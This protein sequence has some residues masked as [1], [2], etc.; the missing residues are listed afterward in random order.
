MNS[1]YIYLYIHKIVI[2]FIEEK[3]R[4]I[5][6]F[7]VFAQ[8]SILVYVRV[9]KSFV[10]KLTM[11]RP[12]DKKKQQYDHKSPK[13]Q[14]ATPTS[15]VVENDPNQ[16]NTGG[17]GGGLKR[18][19][20]HVLSP[21]HSPP[22]KRQTSLPDLFSQREV[23]ASDVSIAI[24]EQ[25]ILSLNKPQVLDKLVR[26][27]EHTGVFRNLEVRLEKAV[28]TILAENSN[29]KTVVLEK[30]K[31]ICEQNQ[32][33]ISLKND[34]RSLKDDIDNFKTCYEMIEADLRKRD[35]DVSDL[36]K[37][38][39]ELKA[40]VEESHDELEQY[41]RRNALRFTNVPQRELNNMNGN[42]DKYVLDMVNKNLG[43]KL[44]EKDISR[45]HMASKVK[46]GKCQILCKFVTYN[47]RREI[48]KKRSALKGV[49]SV[50]IVED[51]TKKRIGMLQKLLKLRYEG[52]I[53]HAWSADGKIL[54]R[55]REGDAPSVMRHW[56]DLP[57]SLLE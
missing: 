37:T 43:I 13:E 1:Q 32:L 38:T 55:V 14:G 25:V 6:Y 36:R 49:S 11:T 50:F 42:T 2:K 34:I 4:T 26:A 27:F 23:T 7:L 20:D 30:Q 17:A 39:K 9:F 57:T 40:Q 56:D 35:K 31:E 21:G 10:S 46:D 33:I 44:T 24:E 16:P 8:D 51:L 29:L 41:G 22:L 53:K 48:I 19:W 54:Y 52:R 45:S 3:S 18:T 12:K 28:E 5:S 15:S 47:I